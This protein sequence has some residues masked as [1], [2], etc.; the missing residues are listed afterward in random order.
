MVAT[1]EQKC[2]NM[3]GVG[4]LATWD[5][6]NDPLLDRNHQHGT[7]L[8]DVVGDP[9]FFGNEQ[10][11]G[12]VLCIS[13][14]SVFFGIFTLWG[15]RGYPNCPNSSFHVMKCAGRIWSEFGDNFPRPYERLP[16]CVDA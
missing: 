15:Y 14:F 10:R 11:M 7:F 3:F 6:C 5:R 13:L 9:L 4:S 12:P 1:G 16:D 2:R 8:S